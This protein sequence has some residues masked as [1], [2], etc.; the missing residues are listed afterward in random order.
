VTIQDTGGFP[1]DHTAHVFDNSDL[2]TGDLIGTNATPI[3]GDALD[4]NT[5]TVTDG[6]SNENF[7]NEEFNQT[8]FN[9]V[10]GDDGDQTQGELSSATNTWFNSD[11]N[12]VNDVTISQTELSDLINYW[13]NE[14]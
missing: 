9:A 3:V 14:L 13:F 10:F 7:D 5:A 6:S 1:G 2:P 12:T 11:D 4:S 8:Q